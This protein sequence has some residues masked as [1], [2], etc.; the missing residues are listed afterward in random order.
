MAAKK[1]KVAQYTVTEADLNL[2]VSNITVLADVLPET[3]EKQFISADLT[4]TSVTAVTASND[5][6]CSGNQQD[7]A[8]VT[9]V[10]TGNVASLPAPS[11]SVK[12]LIN[13]AIDPNKEPPTLIKALEIE[14]RPCYAVYDDF[15]EF[16]KAGVYYHGVKTDREGNLTKTNDYICDP[17][18]IDAGSCD[19]SDHNFGL[20]LR[21]K[22]QR[23]RWRNWLM[24]LD[25]LSG[26]CEELRAELLRQGLRIDH[27]KRNHLPSYLQLHDLKNSLNVR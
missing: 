5:E 9:S 20:M 16:G 6:A 27:H 15:N 7:E 21:F 10:T 22:N 26:S 11:F 17:L 12:T 18:H 19:S 14:H 24:P 25:M 3:S 4:V 13:E 23:Y 8:V 2:T 1:R